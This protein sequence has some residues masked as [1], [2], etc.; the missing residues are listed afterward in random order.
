MLDDL[1]REVLLDHSKSP[2]RTGELDCAAGVPA[3][4][5]HNPLCG[6]QG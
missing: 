4:R 5:V 2:R 1:Y 6:D 3:P